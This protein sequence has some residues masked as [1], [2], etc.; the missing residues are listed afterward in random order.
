MV[1]AAG[2]GASR[3]AAG[4]RVM[5]MLQGPGAYAEHL[6]VDIAART[7]PGARGLWFM[8]QRDPA[9]LEE[10]ASDVA[11]GSQTRRLDGLPPGE[12]PQLSVGALLDLADTFLADP[13]LQ[14]DL[15]EGTPGDAANPVAVFADPAL[16][17]FQPAEEP[18]GC[19]AVRVPFLFPFAPLALGFPGRWAILEH[20]EE[21]TCAAPPLPVGSRHLID[22]R[23]GG[24]HAESIAPREFEPIH[25]LYPGRARHR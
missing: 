12:L 8:M 9:R 3:L 17:P 11:D 7:P 16:A 14:A 19:H 5:G 13:H 23:P 24:V 6:S 21:P 1:D 2:E 22:D 20:L 4:D 10:E 18:F 15:L 25:G